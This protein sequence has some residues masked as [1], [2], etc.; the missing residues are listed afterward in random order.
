MHI[1]IIPSWYKDKQ[2]PNS[3][4]FFEEQARALQ[5]RGHKIGIIAPVFDKVNAKI[6][7]GYSEYDDNGIFTIN[8]SVKPLPIRSNKINNPYFLF[9]L[10]QKAYKNYIKQMGTPD[11]IHSHVYQ[12]AGMLGTYLMKRKKIAHV[13]TEHFSVWVNPASNM[14]PSDVRILANI[15]K[16]SSKSIAVSS[17]LKKGMI[18]YTNNNHHIEVIPNMINDLFFEKGEKMD[19]SSVFRFINIGGLS[20]VKNQLML[21]KSFSNFLTNFNVT[22]ELHI[23][24]NGILK[25]V[26]NAEIKLLKLEKKV[27]LTESLNR[28][29]IKKEIQKSHVGIIS[30]IVETFSIAGIEYMSQGLPVITTNC[31]GPNDYLYPF[32]GII[33][34]SEEE[35]TNAL[36][37]VYTNYDRFNP[38]E[39]AN[40]IKSNFSESVITKRLE[41]IYKEVML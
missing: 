29:A 9:K 40:Y 16:W 24:G 37:E 5:K 7:E 19:K 6:K 20:T 38:I 36:H 30:S 8:Q 15:L 13:F 10:Y 3:G 28:N 26:I 33:I 35:M 4:V 31:G 27:F 12:F 34:N 11:V 21:I 39:I 2:N 23:I 22:A 17:F 32:N 41:K 18:K 14:P 25:D 1:L